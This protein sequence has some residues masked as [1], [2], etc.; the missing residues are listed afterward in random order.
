MDDFDEEIFNI[1]LFGNMAA[2]CFVTVI[3]HLICPD[4]IKQHFTTVAIGVFF[5]LYI[6]EFLCWL[7]HIPEWIS[8]GREWIGKGIRHIHNNTKPKE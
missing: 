6:L 7:L 1:L 4:V 2:T 8:K 3:G 5:G